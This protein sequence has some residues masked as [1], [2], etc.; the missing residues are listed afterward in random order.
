MVS[1]LSP[2]YN[3]RLLNRQEDPFTEIVVYPTILALVTS[4]ETSP[5]LA[6][7]LA[8]IGDC[9]DEDRRLRRRGSSTALAKNGRVERCKR[10]KVVEF[11]MS[12]WRRRLMGMRKKSDGHENEF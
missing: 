8:T 3:T 6:R 7:P 2:C 10:G 4:A 12:D 5:S 11:G 1:L 9:A